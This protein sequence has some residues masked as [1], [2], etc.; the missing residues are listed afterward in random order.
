LTT[1]PPMKWPIS[2]IAVSPRRAALNNSLT[3]K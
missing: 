1:L 2:R 3:L